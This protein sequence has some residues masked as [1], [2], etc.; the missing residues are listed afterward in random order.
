MREE[1]MPDAPVYIFGMGF[2]Y[3]TVYMCVVVTA[4]ILLVAYIIGRRLHLVPGRL[5]S[6]VEAVFGFFT[7]VTEQ[8]LGKEYGR[9]LAPVFLVLFLFIWIS[10][11]IG[12]VPIGR[13]EIGGE[14]YID[15]NGN[16]HFDGMDAFEDENGNGRRDAG[17]VLPKFAEP[18][19]DVCVPI[20]LAIFMAILIHGVQIHAKGLGGYIKDYFSP[21]WM[22]FPLNFIS[23]PMEV[24]STSIRLF[25]NIF[26]GA[27]ILA[28]G[29]IF[30]HYIAL[31][32]PLQLFFGIFVGTIQAF[33]FTVLWLS[34]LAVTIQE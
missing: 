22:L 33:V 9:R 28:I 14:R 18:T 30:V 12:V 25:G 19:K 23:R 3:Q 31:P 13:I 2:N 10:N 8:A 34:Y 7:E 24:V 16:G 26:G 32:V 27:V 11:I 1:I 21:M 4:L 20:G 29:G 6:A 5:Q 17:F 15:V